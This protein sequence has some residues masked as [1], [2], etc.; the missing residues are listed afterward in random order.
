MQKTEML[1]YV[2]INPDEARK[3]AQKLHQKKDEIMLVRK[4]YV[5]EVASEEKKE[6]ERALVARVSTEERDRDGEIIEPAGIDLTSYLKNSVLMWAHRYADPPIGRALWAKLDSKGLVCKFQFA[7]TQ[8]ADEIYQLYKDG[9]LKAFSIGFL[10]LDYDEENKIHRK[11][12]LLEVSAVPVPANEN[13]LVMEAYQKGLLNSDRLKKDLGIDDT[14]NFQADTEITEDV[15]LHGTVVPLGGTEEGVEIITKPEPDITENYIRLR[16]RDP[17]DFVQDSFRTITIS[18]EKGIKAVIGKLKSDP[19]G[20]THIQSY[21]FDKDKWTVEEAQAW[22]REHKDGKDIEV[23]EE[24]KATHKI[25]PIYRERW[26]LKLSKSFDVA[27]IERPPSKFQ[28]EL[29]INFFGCKIKDIFQNNFLIPS[30]LL[31]TYLSAFEKA[32]EKF[33]LI[34]TRNFTWDGNESP[35]DYEIIELNSRQSK[36]FLLG[37]IN[38]YQVDNRK[39]ALIYAPCWFGIEV[40]VVTSAK[41]REWN[42]KFLENVHAWVKENNFLK[43]EKFALNGEFLKRTDEKWESLI[44]EKGIKDT[45][46]KTINQ[47][48]NKKADM[49]SRGMLLVGEP[50]TGKTKTGRIILNELDSTFIWVSSRDFRKVDPI[51]A[52]SLAFEMGRDLAPSVLFIEDIDTWLREYT[53]DLLKTE[54]DGIRQ[55]K[56]IITILTSNTPEKLPDTLLD[57]PGRFH[58][59]IEFPLP[60]VE[61]RK[62]MLTTW[63]GEIAEDRLNKILTETEGFSGAHM[64]ELVDFAKI[65]AKEETIELGDALLRSLE[66][67]SKQRELISRIRENSPKEKEMV[68]LNLKSDIPPEGEVIEKGVIAYHD[69]GAADEGEAWDG[70]AA[71]RA[72]VDVLKK[73]CAWYDSENPDIK[74]SYKL[75]HHKPDGLKA[76]WAGVRAAMGAILGARGGVDIPTGDKKGVYNHLAKHYAHWDKE[77]PEFKDYSEDELKVLFPD[78]YEEPKTEEPLKSWADVATQTLAQVAELRKEIAEFKEGRVISTKNRQLINDAIAQMTEAIEALKALLAATEPASVETDEKQTEPKEIK[79][80]EKKAGEEKKSEVLEAVQW[81]VKSGELA[82]IVSESIQIEMARIRGKVE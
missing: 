72:E 59:V 31:G 18:E 10:P 61:Q 78:F 6:E 17:N 43:G 69:Y 48:K 23:I 1:K 38:F 5:A 22:V 14:A 19:N 81:L 2:D 32:C 51:R 73:I 8:F 46:E 11:I 60:K 39:I 21:L 58:H 13:C 77:A 64:K 41:E 79:E 55:N 80:I 76:V 40:S 12:S 82:K 74:N 20:S 3:M 34:D 47:L 66:Q 54:M 26:N 68:N 29:F 25:M 44:L 50:G 45:I 30:P 37:G 75:P 33:K 28:Y 65:I 27:A 57:R 63:A 62:E 16:Q 4:S 71:M 36:E 7:K 35:P 52:L 15:L 70:P 56:G 24:E 42:K 53:V 67:L 9:Y 49:A